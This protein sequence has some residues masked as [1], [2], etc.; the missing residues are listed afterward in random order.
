MALVYV[1][2]LRATC[3]EVR[4]TGQRLAAGSRHVLLQL[5]VC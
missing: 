4:R 1:S 5:R 3:Y 2:V